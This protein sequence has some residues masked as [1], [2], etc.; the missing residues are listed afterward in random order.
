MLLIKRY[1]FRALRLD[2]AE[3]HHSTPAPVKA[4]EQSCVTCGG[5]YSYR[6]CPATDSSNYRDNIQ[7]YVSQAA[8]ANFNQE[9]SGYR[10]PPMA[11]QIRPPVE[12]EVT[13]DTVL[14]NE[15][16]KDVQPPIVQVDE[17]V[18]MPRAKTTLP[19]PSRV[20]KEKIRE[21]DE[22]LA[23][24]FMEIFRNLHFELSF[25]DALLH[26]PKFAPI[27]PPPVIVLPFP[28]LKDM[29]R[30]LLFL[31]K[32]TSPVPAPSPVKAL[33]KLCYH[34]G[35]AANF[36]QGNSG[37][38]PHRPPPWANQIRPP[39]VFPSHATQQP[40]QQSESLEPKPKPWE[41]LQ[42]GSN[43]TTPGSLPSNTVANPKCELKAIT[44]RSGVS[45]IWTLQIPPPWCNVETESG[46]RE[47]ECDPEKDILLLEAISEYRVIEV[48]R[49]KID[50][51]DR[52][53][54]DV[55][56]KLPHPTTV[57]G[58]CSFLGHA[59]FYRRFI[60]NFSEIARPMTHL[61][62]KE[63]PFYFSKECIE[64]FNIL[65]RNLT[66]APILIAPDWNEPFE[67]MCDASDFALGDVN[68]AEKK[69][70]QRVKHY[71]WEDPFLFKIC[72]DQV[73]RR[74]GFWQRTMD[75]LNGLPT[76][77]PPVDITVL[78]TQQEKSSIP[79]S[80]G[81]QSTKMPMNWLKT[82]THASVKE[83]FHNVDEMPQNSIQVCEIFERLKRIFKKRSKKKA[84]DK[85]I[86]ARSGKGK[87]KKKDKDV[88][89]KS[90]TFVTLTSPEEN[91]SIPPGI[92]LA[93]PPTFEVSSSNPT[94][95]L[96]LTGEIAFL[97]K[98]PKTSFLHPQNL[99]NENQGKK[100][101][102][103]VSSDVPID[104]IVLAI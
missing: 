85:Q 4:I 66:E 24:K 101:V 95:L 93:L 44:T 21:K 48:D 52:A 25:A 14:P 53:K 77:V 103:E 39:P 62:K 94:F 27:F 59:G 72:A 63:T 47:A 2:K 6:N 33:A 35:A 54:I 7:E 11:N 49:A 41:W 18:V 92:D 10:L 40:S 57:K 32:Q 23:L 80:F 37:Y 60:Q 9:N 20:N 22:L 68:P 65:K 104:P 86:Q 5:A 28:E 88:E 87:V 79:D 97:H 15:S 55:I 96:S 36:T 84:K 34:C 31:D 42:P 61:I 82:A 50:L 29:V 56:A 89:I 26:M 19:Y 16:T 98:E 73:I 43:P 74:C 78:T 83:K 46:I 70:L 1:G 17:P 91:V 51:V 67:L 102:E 3:H 58:V 81:P 71:F 13:K 69:I 8:A 64:A 12:T 76:M 38:E 99:V 90:S 30:A 100:N 45:S 75:I